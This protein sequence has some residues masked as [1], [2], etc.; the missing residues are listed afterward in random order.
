MRTKIDWR[1]GSKENYNDFCKKNPSV[2]I[3]FDNWR[4]ILYTYN[5]SFKEYIEYFGY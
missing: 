1:S 5:E 4:N 2:K 3:T